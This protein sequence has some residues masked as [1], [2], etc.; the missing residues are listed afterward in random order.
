MLHVGVLPHH[1]RWGDVLHNL[2]V[3]VVDEAHVY[4]GVFGSHVANVL[5]RLRRLARAYGA[6]P[7]FVLASATIAN[8]GELA[9]RLTG[10]DVRVVDVDTSPRA[11]REV[12]LWNPELL[13]EELGVRASALGDASRL[14]AGLVGSG[15]RVICFTKSRKAAELVH[16][17]ASDRLDAATARRLAPYRA[18][19]TPEQR[20]EIERRLVE[21]ELLGVTATNALELGIDIG[22]LDCAISVGFPGTVASLR[23][24]WGRAGRRSR[25]LAVLVAS[26]DALDQFFVNE[27]AALLRADGRGGADRPR[28]APDPRRPRALG[29]LRGAADRGRCR[30]PRA[31]G[32]RAGGGPARARVDARRVRLARQGHARSAPVAP[33][34]GLRGLRDRRRGDGHGARHGRARARLLHGAR[35]RRLPPSRRPVR[36]DRARSRDP[37]G[38]RATGDGRLVH[39]GAEGDARP[40]SSS[41]CACGGWPAS[42][43]T[44]A[45]SP[46]PSR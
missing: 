19:Y 6:E 46:S 14:L 13:D 29:G 33:L 4:R 12:V 44:T 24:Q 26:E 8:A 38:P 9:T 30:D 1:D 42:S 2:R 27:P 45:G 39:A 10:L 35:G 32:A 16:R 40:R 36:R 41:P 7:V 11:E 5:R 17:F 20:R 25:G 37:H 18:G 23:Q 43:S 21:G 31:R 15:L 22:T 34:G 3:V 28:D